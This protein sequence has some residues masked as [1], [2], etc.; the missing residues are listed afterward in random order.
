MTLVSTGWFGGHHLPAYSVLF[1]LLA[2][3]VG[4][5]LVGV[6]A[7]V[8]ASAAFGVLAGAR[9][10]ALVVPGVLAA[11]VAGQATFVL[12]AAFG[13]A[14][15]SAAN[16]RPP[17]EKGQA[18]LAGWSRVALL[19]VLT[20]LA[21]PVAAL[22]AGLA[23]V[24]LRSW[25]L[26]VAVFVPTL[27]LAIAFGEGGDFPFVLSSFAPAFVAGVAVA[28]AAP[29]GSPLAVGGALYALLSLAVF[30]VPTP[31]GGNAVRLGTL[32]AIPVA[33]HLLWPRRRVGLAVL[34]LPLA[35]WV[36]QPAARAVI[37]T[38]DDPSM[39]ASFFTPLERELR[40]PIRIEVPLTR[41]KRETAVLP[42]RITLA[43]G[44]ERQLDRRRNALFYGDLTADEYRAWL[45]DNAVSVVALPVGVPL[46]PSSEDEAELLRSGVLGPERRVGAWRLYDVAAESLGVT[47]LGASSFTVRGSGVVRVR[48]S[49]YWAITRGRGCVARA[50]KWTRVRA[51]GPGP[52]TVEARFA[53]DRVRAESPRCR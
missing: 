40:G 45:R 44:W 1:P 35:Y 19:G 39:R 46:D 10:G 38:N 47:E 36:V 18:L 33:V 48:Y 16:P 29:R 41:N 2:S 12:G 25:V 34:A 5:R 28:V 32:V 17:S 42:P 23:A 52:I 37:T 20:A 26:A 15:V 31:V 14:A 27:L 50:G 4:E 8:L 21:S 13:V 49:S 51:N 43:R 6:L 9:L 7:A 30:V 22:F 53:L 3:V 11:L 24:A